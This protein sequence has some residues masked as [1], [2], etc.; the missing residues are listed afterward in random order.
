M[1]YST[2]TFTFLDLR[3]VALLKHSIPPAEWQ[4][5]R[6]VEIHAMFYRRYDI[7]HAMEARSV[8]QLEAWPSAYTALA[9]LPRLRKLRIVIA[10]P[11]HLDARCPAGRQ[12]DVLLG[13]WR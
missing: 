10:K 1:L 11:S 5:I 7:E 6:F 3:I 2:N 4:Q 9:S 13:V 8:L 12:S